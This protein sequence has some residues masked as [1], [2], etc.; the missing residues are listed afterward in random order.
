[1]RISEITRKTKETD[2][3]L[4]IDLDGIGD[5]EI[6]TGSAFLDHMLTLF[7]K[8]GRFDLYVK[9][10]GDVDV[11]CHHTTEDIGICLGQ[12]FAKALGEKVGIVRY[13]DT[14]L[15][16][17]ETLIL[18]A[19]DISGRGF[20]VFDAEFAGD[21]CGTMD[22]Q[23]FEEFFRSFAFNANITLHVQNLYGTNDHHKAE[24]M[25]KATARA[26]RQAVSIDERFAGQVVSTKGVL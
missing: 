11:D 14:T 21:M 17:D 3:Y 20:I 8:H 1:M 18:C 10:R 4:Q 26:L 9:C 5:S 25:F 12:A 6:N 13:A 24:S 15:P 16:M 23:L 7:A 19:V 22:T 2:I